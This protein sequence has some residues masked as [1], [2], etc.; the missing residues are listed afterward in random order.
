MRIPSIA[1]A[2]A[3]ALPLALLVPVDVG[4]A[5]WAID[6]GA[7]F[8]T[9]AYR[10]D[11]QVRTGRF[12]K[13]DPQLMLD[14]DDLGKT[15]GVLGVS[16]VSLDLGDAMRETILATKP[17]LDAENHPTASFVVERFEMGDQP[18][19]ATAIGRLEIKGVSLPLSVPVAIMRQGGRATAT[20]ALR[21]DR[22]D[23]GLRDAFVESLV[24]I[25]DEIVLDFEIVA[26]RR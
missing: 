6:T 10:E 24:S 19:R 11:G 18:G 16:V 23:Y 21:F 5:D 3:I 4:A 14:P 22:L 26:N 17:W 9:F 12:D 1:V 15:R 13:I 8:V 25:A 2:V 7:S 20:G